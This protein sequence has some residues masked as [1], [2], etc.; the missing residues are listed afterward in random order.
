M[1][2]IPDLKITC[3]VSL[4]KSDGFIVNVV[5]RTIAIDAF[6]PLSA[7][8]AK[9]EVS[10]ALKSNRLGDVVGK[11]V[12]LYKIRAFMVD[13]AVDV[14][15]V[16]AAGYNTVICTSPPENLDE[17]RNS[18]LKVAHPGGADYLYCTGKLKSSQLPVFYHT[19]DTDIASLSYPNVHILFDAD[20]EVFTSLSRRA[21]IGSFMPIDGLGW[22]RDNRF[23]GAVYRAKDGPFSQCLQWIAGQSMYRPLSDR[24]LFAMWLD[25]YHPEWKPFLSYEAVL[26]PQEGLLDELQRAFRFKKMSEDLLRLK[27]VLQ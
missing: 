16:I 27:E 19:K 12:P 17:I 6:T 20:D 5:G 13:G 24:V 3:K 22:Q 21:H 7:T 2:H 18:G 23:T 11:N 25:R 15:K 9:S 10:L 8:F 14:E 4:Q 26:S 1:T